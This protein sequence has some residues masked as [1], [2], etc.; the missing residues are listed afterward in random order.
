[1]P[2]L[3]TMNQISIKKCAHPKVRPAQCA[4]LLNPGQRADGAVQFSRSGFKQSKDRLLLEL[5][6]AN[7]VD[8]PLLLPVP[9]VAPSGFSCH[10]GRRNFANGF[11]PYDKES[12]RESDCTHTYGAVTNLARGPNDEN[13]TPKISKNRSGT[14]TS[15]VMGRVPMFHFVLAR[16]ARRDFQ[17]GCDLRLLVWSREYPRLPRILTNY[18]HRR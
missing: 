18:E 16:S 8:N 13:E 10:K 1:M 15:P 14:A 2:N 4:Q 6:T 5:A 7:E 3:P 9:F 12:N 17:T 11:F